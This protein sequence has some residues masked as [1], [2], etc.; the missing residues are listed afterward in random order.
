M[1]LLNASIDLS[2]TTPVKELKYQKQ[3]AYTGEFTQNKWKTPQK[4]SH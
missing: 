2:H 3:K 4:V 1:V